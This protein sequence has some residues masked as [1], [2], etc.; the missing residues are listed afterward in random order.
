[1]GLFVISGKTPYQTDCQLRINSEI[2][3]IMIATQLNLFGS[4]PKPPAKILEDEEDTDSKPE[5]SKPEETI[6]D[7][8]AAEENV[9]SEV[10]EPVEEKKSNPLPEPSHISVMMPS[11]GIANLGGKGIYVLRPPE[12][13]VIPEV[14]LTV[15]QTEMPIVDQTV[16]PAVSEKLPELEPTEDVADPK[17]N[18]DGLSIEIEEISIT[19]MDSLYNEILP[20]ESVEEEINEN[21]SPA[22]AETTDSEKVGSTDLET[23]FIPSQVEAESVNPGVWPERGESLSEL[24]A[25]QKGGLSIPS[26]EELFKRQYYSMRDTANM[27]GVNQSLLRF[28]ENEFSILKPKKNKKGDRYFRPIDIKHL[29]LIYHL[30]RVRKFTIEGAREYLKNSN[31]ALDNFALV[32]RMVQLKTFLQELKVNL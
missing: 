4:I 9:Y 25:S 32:E 22:A 18:T 1:M 29:Q 15:E 11:E 13:T 3:C 2:A 14:I 31:R 19:E 16:L 26:D 17:A 5:A 27:F 30:L 21:Q 24:P 10:V 6:D 28:W 7:S 12:Q 8:V 20:N 23:E